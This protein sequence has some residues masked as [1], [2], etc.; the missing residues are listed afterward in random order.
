MKGILLWL[1]VVKVSQEL[2]NQ[3]NR[4]A[5]PQLDVA[6]V[7]NPSSHQHNESQINAISDFSIDGINEGIN[8]LLRHQTGGHKH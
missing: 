5:I 8:C 3:E 1:T 4:N 6:F 7:H 2:P